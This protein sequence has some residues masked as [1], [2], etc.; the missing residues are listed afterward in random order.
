ME[1]KLIGA[2]ESIKLSPAGNIVTYAVY[3]YM[4]GELGPFTFEV[5]KAEDTAAA[6]EAEMARKEALLSEVAGETT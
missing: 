3:T 1:R 5:P 6:L 2:K 4:L